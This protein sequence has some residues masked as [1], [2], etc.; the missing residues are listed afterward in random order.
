MRNE[1]Q[2]KED[3]KVADAIMEKYLGKGEVKNRSEQYHEETIATRLKFAQR[4]MIEYHMSTGRMTE[5]EL[6]RAHRSLRTVLR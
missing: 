2:A 6:E 4:D 3:L 5:K 1:K